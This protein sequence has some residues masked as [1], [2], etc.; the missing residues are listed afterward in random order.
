M[1]PGKAGTGESGWLAWERKR[2]ERLAARETGLA[3]GHT[4]DRSGTIHTF[5]FER[6]ELIILGITILA[7]AAAFFGL[8]I[9]GPLSGWSPDI[10]IS[11][12]DEIW[13][14][15][16]GLLCS[17][18]AVRVLRRAVRVKAGRV[19]IRGYLFTRTINAGDIRAITLQMTRRSVSEESPHWIPRI[20]LADGRS[21]W[22][23]AL[24]CGP[25]D[26]PPRPYR[27]ASLDELRGI[28]GVETDDA[29]QSGT[30]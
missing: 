25:S 3:W 5:L 19:T 29:G 7:F 12:G 22:I 9:A 10:D 17:W 6:G 18:L 21:I 1:R 11:K 23:F 28:L 24:D 14:T 4:V 27:A 30:R 20:D 16:G 13:T 2:A 8:A 26:R 15:A